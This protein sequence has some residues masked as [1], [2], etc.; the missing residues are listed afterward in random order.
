[1]VLV[2]ETTD[3]DAIRAL[4]EVAKALKLNFRIEPGDDVVPSAERQRRLKVLK[5][6][7]GSLKKYDTGYQFDKLEWYQQL[8]LKP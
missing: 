3:S 8:S 6:F 4:A 7:K 5:K 1:M 2:I